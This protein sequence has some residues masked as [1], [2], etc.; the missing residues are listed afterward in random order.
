MK[1][2][3]IALASSKTQPMAVTMHVNEFVIG[4]K[5]VLNLQTIILR[6]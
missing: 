5:D 1:K 4:G 6:I 3:K 2:G